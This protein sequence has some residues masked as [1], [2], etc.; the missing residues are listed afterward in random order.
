MTEPQER[1]FRLRATQ[2]IEVAAIDAALREAE[3][4]CT[5][6]DTAKLT[7]IYLDDEAGRL[8]RAGIGLRLREDRRGRHLCCKHGSRREGA[9]FVRT[10]IE[11]SWPAEA[12]PQQAAELPA[13]L[14]DVVE[15]FLLGS[16]LVPVLR[17]ETQRETRQLAADG[18]PVGEVAIDQVTMATGPQ[19]Q[20]F[21]EVEI[22]AH[23]DLATCERLAAQ[24]AEGLPLAAAADDKPTHAAMLLGLPRTRP[25]EPPTEADSP[26]APAIAAS[27]QRH[28]AAMQVAEAGVRT[29]QDPAHLHDMRVALRRLR[30][31]VRAFRGLWPEETGNRMLTEL[32]DTA[33]RLGTVRDLDVMLSSLPA[34]IATLPPGLLDAAHAAAAWIRSQRA[35]EHDALL[36]WLRNAERLDR[37]RQLRD[38]LA[39]PDG[40]LTTGGTLAAVAGARLG[41]ASATV[42][43]LTK[44]MDPA[45]P[46]EPLHE[47][48]IACKRLRY[49]GEEFAAM[50]ELAPQKPLAALAKLQLALGAVCDHETAAAQ[51]V[52]W[53]PQL[54]QEQPAA[55]T[56]VGGLATSHHLAAEAA[57]KQARKHVRRAVRK[58]LWRAFPK[59]PEQ[60]ATLAP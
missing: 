19:Q 11:E 45:L 41:D 49:L 17:L 54:Q 14:R 8:A 50:P 59:P 9:L 15:P 27:A 57:R 47:L 44:A 46:I 10:E 23:D 7:D 16:R 51:L 22:E 2:P 13:T 6:A 55:A 39:A 18:Q 31:L 34:T 21:L 32:G 40:S 5:A 38:A 35:T 60:D 26:A 52:G 30:S 37:S 3:L 58:K 4:Q 53:L 48:R 43:R 56:A 36:A 20:Q 25:A 24:L 29:S 1:E 33:R 42:R 28:F 12:P